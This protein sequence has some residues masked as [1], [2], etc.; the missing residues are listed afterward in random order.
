MACKGCQKS[1]RTLH[2]NILGSTPWVYVTQVLS[3][4]DPNNLCFYYN[5]D[6]SFKFHSFC[7]AFFLWLISV[8]CR[9]FR[10]VNGKTIFEIFQNSVQ[11]SQPE[12]N[13]FFV[14]I[15]H[16]I[17]RELY[18]PT[19]ITKPTYSTSITCKIQL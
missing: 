5:F 16:L 11:V 10:S 1:F 18:K 14:A 13:T 7:S 9:Q 3:L 8:C 12:Q 6:N 15:P 19:Y 4:T 2:P 17:Y